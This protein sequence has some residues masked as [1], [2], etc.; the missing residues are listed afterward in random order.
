MK[1][2]EVANFFKT[3]AVGALPSLLI[4]WLI[5]VLAPAS[6]DKL[7][8]TLTGLLVGVIIVPAL[9]TLLLMFPV[10][11]AAQA[12][13]RRWLAVA[14]GALPITLLHLLNGW[15]NAVCV[16]WLFL[17]WADCYLRLRDECYGVGGRYLY[18]LGLHASWNACVFGAAVIFS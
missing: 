14:I 7:D 12:N 2:K 11:L 6:S 18:L 13:R 3:L 5:S 16:Y 17:C 10:H 9:E 8:V 15:R 4:A 1:R